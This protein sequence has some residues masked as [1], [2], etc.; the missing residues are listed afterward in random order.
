MPV[1]SFWYALA[2]TLVFSRC[3]AARG[4][5]RPIPKFVCSPSAQQSPCPDS[6]FFLSEG[7]PRVPRRLREQS[8]LSTSSAQ[9]TDH[10]ALMP[11]IRLPSFLSSRASIPSGREGS[12]GHALQDEEEREAL[13][14]EDAVT[15]ADEGMVS[16]RPVKLLCKAHPSARGSPPL[17]LFPSPSLPSPF[18]I[19]PLA[20]RSP[21]RPGIQTRE[22][23]RA[24]HKSVES[25]ELQIVKQSLALHVAP[26]QRIRQRHSL[27]TG[28]AD[29]ADHAQPPNGA[30]RATPW[31]MGLPESDMTE[32]RPR[33]VARKR[34][35]TWY[36]RVEVPEGGPSGEMPQHG[37]RLLEVHQEDPR[38]GSAGSPVASC[39]RAP[40]V[41]STWPRGA[42]TPT[43][44]PPL[45][46]TAAIHCSPVAAAPGRSNV[47]APC[48]GSSSAWGTGPPL[49]VAGVMVGENAPTAPSAAPHPASLR[50]GGPLNPVQG[51]QG[52]AGRPS[53]EGL[54]KVVGPGTPGTLELEEATLPG[55]PDAGR[56]KGKA[57][58]EGLWVWSCEERG[59]G[60]GRR[61]SLGADGGARHGVWWSGLEREEVRPRS[62]WL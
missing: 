45:A 43:S 48:M 23:S 52:T 28:G 37:S 22:S 62:R 44:E 12:S 18:H 31:E 30:N 3:R 38:E 24:I 59:K 42:T 21:L 35:H 55:G 20:S 17:L 15:S 16:L 6:V 32:L 11:V 50:M 58:R 39:P 56:E 14:P 9:M 40:V 19:L 33:L 2:A 4:H 49:P 54:F 5:A 53:D 13:Q 8:G 36:G 26:T 25:L 34:C 46:G 10:E 57:G 51:A 29:N 60:S 61:R 47:A 41:E 1:A 7:R 27:V